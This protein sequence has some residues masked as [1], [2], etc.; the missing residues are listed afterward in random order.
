MA[1]PRPAPS[2]LLPLSLLLTI[3]VLWGF[4]LVLI[5]TGVTGGVA[6]M[7]YLFWFT[8]VAGTTLLGLC[9][10]RGTWPRLGRVH[11]RYYLAA[12]SLRFVVANIILYTVQGRVPVGI[13]AVLLAMVP[14][15]TYAISLLVRFE[16]FQTLRFGGILCAFAGVVLIVAPRD[17]LPETALVFWILLGLAT[18]LLHGAGYVFLSER[19]RPPGSDSLSVACGT[20]Y[21]ASAL[22]LPLALAFGQ[23]RFILPPF[24]QGELAMLTHA[25]LAGFNF[26]AIFELIRIS[27]ATYM[28]QA[29][30]LSVFFGVVFGIVL[31]DETHSW[32][33]WGAMAVI[34]L[35]V[36]LVNARPQKEPE[37]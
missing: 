9:V 31:F 30:F 16:R 5:K 37:K 22:T 26:Y 6:P 36:A 28:S 12:A 32:W 19:N 24:S 8:L 27:G 13:M 18:P 20:L 25:I 23:F 2:P 35:G 29:N 10:L 3:G 15:F 34:V 11:L 7:T 21:A 17:A 1:P 33:V 14:I 4:F